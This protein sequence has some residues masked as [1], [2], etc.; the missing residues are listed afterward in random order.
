MSRPRTQEREP[1]PRRVA[2]WLLVLPRRAQLVFNPSARPPSRKMQTSK[3][4][5][6]RPILPHLADKRES[7]E[8]SPA[9]LL[10]QLERSPPRV[11]PLERSLKHLARRP[12]E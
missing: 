8:E 7:Q 4:T 3:M 6:I 12:E 1:Q 2:R 5:R 10:P 9:K 11:V